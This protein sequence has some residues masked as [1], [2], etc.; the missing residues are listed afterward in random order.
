MFLSL[1]QTSFLRSRLLRPKTAEKPWIIQFRLWLQKI[2]SQVRQEAFGGT[3]DC[4]QRKERRRLCLNRE[5][6]EERGMEWTRGGGG[7]VALQKH[8][9]TPG[10]GFAGGGR[11]RPRP[12]NSSVMPSRWAVSSWRRA[13]GRG[14]GSWHNTVMKCNTWARGRGSKL[15]A[16][17][18]TERGGGRRMK[19]HH[20]GSLLIR[21]WLLTYI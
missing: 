4:L 8:R 19:L 6:R 18:W 13:G 9:V 16:E 5:E 14:G 11:L 3:V 12:V 7:G 20:S 17:D 21:L 10:F 2:S 15:T 1:L